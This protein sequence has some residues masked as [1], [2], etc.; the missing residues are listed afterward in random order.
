[1]RGKDFKN[2]YCL[3]P[4]NGALVSTLPKADTDINNSGL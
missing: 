3:L 4:V 1:M 2:V